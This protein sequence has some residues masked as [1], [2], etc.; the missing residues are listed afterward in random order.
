MTLRT[1]DFA[2]TFILECPGPI[3][4]T[5]FE[6]VFRERVAPWSPRRGDDLSMEIHRQGWE[7]A[8]D[9]TSM[10]IWPPFG[11]WVGTHQL[12]FRRLPSPDGPSPELYY[13]IPNEPRFEY[14]VVQLFKSTKGYAPFR[15]SEARDREFEAVQQCREILF[16]LVRSSIQE[17]RP[18]FV[19]GDGEFTA[20]RKREQEDSRYQVWPYT[21][22]SGPLADAL[23]RSRIASLAASGRWSVSELAG[24]VLIQG[25]P[26]CLEFESQWCREATG[27]LRPREQLAHFVT[28]KVP[29]PPLDTREPPPK[30]VED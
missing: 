30:G 9:T 27:V 7:T 20:I 24:G 25:M 11:R 26:D 2:S 15:L 8:G 1:S 19:W 23:D 5:N 6:P 4:W 13:A 29:P 14:L 28:R 16:N 22:Y 3:G 17:L 12:I 10:L 21:Y 18:N